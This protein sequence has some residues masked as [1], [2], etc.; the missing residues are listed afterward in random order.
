[1]RLFNENLISFLSEIFRYKILNK[2][3]Y[4]N[5]KYKPIPYSYI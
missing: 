4:F 3:F 5:I 1:M 2:I